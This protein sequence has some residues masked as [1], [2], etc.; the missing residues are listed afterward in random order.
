V[1]AL[2]YLLDAFDF[3][4]ADHIDP[5]GAGAFWQADVFLQATVIVR[6]LQP[7]NPLDLWVG[8]RIK[9]VFYERCNDV[10]DVALGTIPVTDQPLDKG[11]T[12]MTEVC[13]GLSC[14]RFCKCSFVCV[15]ADALKCAI[16][17]CGMG[18]MGSSPVGGE[19]VS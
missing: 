4:R 10:F 1:D 5:C 14:H 15:F 3:V 12:C 6:D 16:F 7:R 2:V 17:E 13:F 9:N 8:T 18:D 19:I 11:G